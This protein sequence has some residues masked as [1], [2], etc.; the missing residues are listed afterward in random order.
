MISN[1]FKHAFVASE[2]GIVQ[3]HFDRSK[4]TNYFMVIDNGIG[5][6][7]NFDPAKSKSLGLRIVN[8]ISKQLK[9]EYTIQNKNGTEFILRFPSNVK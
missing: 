6:P 3:I 7:P 8:M 1:I 4:G 5:I 9:G 2:S